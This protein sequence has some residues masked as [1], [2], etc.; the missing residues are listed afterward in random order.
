[1]ALSFTIWGSVPS[2]HSISTGSEVFRGWYRRVKPSFSAYNDAWFCSVKEQVKFSFFFFF[3]DWKFKL[4]IFS[5]RLTVL[6]FRFMWYPW[7]VFEL[8]W[9]S[10]V[11]QCIDFGDDVANGSPGLSQLRTE[12]KFSDSEERILWLKNVL[13]KLGSPHF[14]QFHDML[15]LSII[16]YIESDIRPWQS[17]WYY[18]L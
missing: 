2:I 17:M 9:H 16:K 11:W 6:P 4:M 10:Y 3:I 18:V 13:E 5:G 1:M 12:K 7:C 15:L 8:W 14:R